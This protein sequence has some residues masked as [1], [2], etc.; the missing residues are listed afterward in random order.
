METFTAEFKEEMKRKLR[1]AL[2]SLHAEST[3]ISDY[4][5][6]KTVKLPHGGHGFMA[7]LPNGTILKAVYCD[8]MVYMFKGYRLLRSWS[9]TAIKDSYSKISEPVKNKNKVHQAYFKSDK[10]IGEVA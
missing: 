8:S 9:E 3:K 1:N 7:K 2:K 5:Q 10:I 6:P 4:V